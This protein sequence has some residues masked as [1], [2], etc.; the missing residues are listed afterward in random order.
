MRAKHRTEA[1]HGGLLFT[2][3]DIPTTKAEALAWLHK[4][5]DGIY[6]TPVYGK[7]AV[8]DEYLAGK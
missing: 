5:C 4:A 8:S 3:D 2:H 1:E 6:T 7:F